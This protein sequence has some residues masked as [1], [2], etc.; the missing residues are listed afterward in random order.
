MVEWKGDLNRNVGVFPSNHVK[1]C[2]ATEQLESSDTA[3]T[4][5]NSKSIK[6]RPRSIKLAAY[7]VKKGD[8]GSI[9]VGGT[10]SR[11]KSAATIWKNIKRIDSISFLK[12]GL[13]CTKL[14]NE[15]T[16]QQIESLQIDAAIYLK[17]P[18]RSIPSESLSFSNVIVLQAPLI[19]FPLPLLS[20][21]H[22]V[23]RMNLLR[24]VV[25][26]Q[27]NIS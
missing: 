26:Q 6:S 3:N 21:L 15:V 8:M 2:D 4:S 25:N 7:G 18:P 20:L 12:A 5:G 24:S 1:L 9:L 14:I 17:Q 27:L 19:L 22:L 10:N 23:L 11:K 16:N 13:G